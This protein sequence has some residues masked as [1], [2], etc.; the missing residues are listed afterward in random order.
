MF[1]NAK[2][3]KWTGADHKAIKLVVEMDGEW[4]G[5]IASPTDC[6]DYGPMLYNFAVNG[7]FGPVAA[8]DEERIIE[9]ELPVPDGYAVQD[10]ELVNVA[11]YE[12]EATAELARR[13]AELQTPE[14]LAQAELDENYAAE[15]KVKLAALLA[16]KTQPLWPVE[17]EW[18]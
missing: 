17:V 13:L 2:N 7:I 4:A 8:S 11:E 15:R 5:F 1:T 14:A 6:T 9:G 12:Q 10:G 3:P 16:V 18:P